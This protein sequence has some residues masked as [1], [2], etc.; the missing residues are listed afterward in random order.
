MQPLFRQEAV[1]H[2]T[3]LEG[4]VLLPASVSVWLIG[5]VLAAVL[6][7]AIWFATTATYAR[8]ETVQ[9][10][11]S[12]AAGTVRVVASGRGVVSALLVAEGDVVER[13]ASLARIGL[14]DQSDAEPGGPML[15]RALRTQREAR[16]RAL[17][18]TVRRLALGAE[19]LDA[20]RS[21]LRDEL[22]DVE[23]ELAEAGSARSDLKRAAKRLERELFDVTKELETVPETEAVARAEA[24][25][26]LAG[27]DERL[28]RL[29]MEVERVVHAP[30]GG[31]IA[32]VPVRIGHSVTPGAS[33]AVV[34]PDDSEL[35]A[36]LFVP[37]R[38]AG[39][40][41][42]GQP[43]RLKYDAFP[44]QRFG[45]Q[46]G[47]VAEV[48]LAVLSPEESGLSAGQPAEP[49]FRVRGRLAAQQLE[50][51]GADMP[52]RAGMRLTADIVVDRR[53]LIEWL[54]D[55]L[56]AVGRR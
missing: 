4:R 41:A 9:G 34:V 20:R 31:R 39:F 26:A 44:F 37:S 29:A 3:R 38:A 48:S 56:Y 50:A 33:V 52:L 19:R 11:L 17:R 10:W 27:I 28:A 1:A 8:T 25:G 43:L 5:A 21:L 42:V 53:T 16:E 2:A 36:E 15:L 30:V 47:V 6:G 32:A 7:L 12:P 51:Y 49:V 14:L 55:P 46:D 45:A 18:A 54:L 23:V 24:E 35:V 13:G 40:V 22:A